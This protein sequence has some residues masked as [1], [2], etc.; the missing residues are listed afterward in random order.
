MDLCYLLGQAH[1]KLL[2]LGK[3]MTSDLNDPDGDSSKLSQMKFSQFVLGLNKFG[4]NCL[5]F[6]SLMSAPG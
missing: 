2:Q 5:F 3:K 4:I 6:D 1:I